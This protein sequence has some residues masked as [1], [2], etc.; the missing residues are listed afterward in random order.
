V[1]GRDLGWFVVRPRA[2]REPVQLSL[3]DLGAGT[4]SLGP[5]R[6]R[7]RRMSTPDPAEPD[8]PPEPDP[9]EPDLPPEE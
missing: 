8:L 9:A 6:K 3:L 7:A 1:K 5:K 4:I 2:P